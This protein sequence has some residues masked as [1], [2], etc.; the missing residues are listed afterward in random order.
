[1]LTNII[2]NLRLMVL[3]TENQVKLTYDIVTELNMDLLERINSKDDY[4]DN[5]KT[6]LENDCFSYIHQLD[7]NVDQRYINEIRA[8]HIIAVNLERI[9]DYCVNITRQVKYLSETAFIHQ[10]DFGPMFDEIKSALSKVSGVLV[11]KDLYSA[12]N[13]C[14]SEFI[15]D[16]HYED[17]FTQILK[18]VNNSKY[19]ENLI[20]VIFIYRYLERIGDSLLNIGEALIFAIIGDRIK[21]RQVEALQSTL[22]HSDFKG[23]LTDIDVASIWGSRSG[24]RISRIE[25]NKPSGFKAQGIFKEGNIKK[26]TEERERIL[27]WHDILPGLAP[28]VFGFNQKENTASLLVEFLPGC[29]IDQ[30]A[31]TET[32]DTI[33]QMLNLFET[34]ILETWSITKTDEPFATNYM[35]Q[36]E[37]R[38]SAV[39]NVHPYF[40]R[41]SQ[42]IGA[43]NVNSTQDLIDR[44]KEIESKYPAPFSVRIHGDFNAN[45]IIFN[46]EHRRINYIDLHRSRQMDYIQDASVLLVS[47]FRLPVFEESLR[48]RLNKM[49]QHF[50]QFF[51]EFAEQNR[52]DTFLIRLSLALARSFFTSSRFEL[53]LSFAKEM[54]FRSNYLMERVVKYNFAEGTYQFP[55]DILY[56]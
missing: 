11:S 44:C 25:D 1:M 47:F 8:I 52:D 43:L 56:Y 46:A 48:R 54:V 9:A 38:F 4:I 13:I 35:K 31:L 32:E 53:K 45:N 26:I 16:E 50:F 5:L 21:I 17:N 10:F 51:N 3:E 14:K 41:N 29:T 34:T 36:L 24:C 6:T 37:D 19:A 49:V 15:L 33:R 28:Q 18:Q 20:T 2:E 7:E 23:D 22:Q 30:V 40:T 39:N 27:E 12:L 42:G 55:S